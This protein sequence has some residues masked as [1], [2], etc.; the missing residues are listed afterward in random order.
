MRVRT[1]FEHE[2]YRRRGPS[3]YS[4]AFVMTTPTNDVGGADGRLAIART[5]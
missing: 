1:K 3:P 2:K 5:A 4:W